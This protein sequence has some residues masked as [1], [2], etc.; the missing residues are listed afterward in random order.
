MKKLFSTVFIFLLAIQ[1]GW[2]QEPVSIFKSGDDGYKS[3]RIPAIVA[4]SKNNIIAIAEGRVNNAGDYGN[5]D[6]VMKSSKDGGKTW[7]ALKQVVDVGNLQAGNPAPVIDMQDPRYPKGRL[8]IFYNV[9]NDHEG[10]VRKGNG[11][12]TVWYVA[13]TDQGQTWG[14]PVEIT[15]QVHRPNKP[16]VNPS[17]NFK[18]DWRSYANT[19]GHAMQIEAGK[20][21]GRIYVAANHS[22][23]NPQS[24]AKDYQA[25]G[26]YTDDHGDTFKLGATVDYL[27]SNEST[28]AELSDSRLM[29]NSRNQQGNERARIISISSDGGTTWDTTYV[30]HNLPDPV[31]QGSILTIGKKKGKN[32]LA[33]SNAADQKNR[34]NLTLRISFDDGQTWAKSILVDKSE[35]GFKGA[36]TAYSDIVKLGKKNIGI[37]YEKDNYTDIVFKSIKWK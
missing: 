36:W 33:F 13:S 34:D 14:Q 16:D 35:E 6:I 2:S 12:R 1:L 26:F 8:F 11:Y 19:P 9:G 23:G 3:Y 27:G 22:A 20:Y 28:A 25:H 7:S 4:F 29:M 24:A 18:E 15:T 5:I 37:L 10:E 17:W 32:I 21:K 31:N 30:D